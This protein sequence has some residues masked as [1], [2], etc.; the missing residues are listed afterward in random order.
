[1]CG[2]AGFVDRSE[3]DPNGALRR[4]LGLIAH[5]GPD[6][7]G[8]HFEPD[9]GLAM[10]TRRLSIID[11]EGGTQPIWSEDGN[12]GVT[13]NGE[14]FNYLELR[15][16]LEGKGHR[17]RTRSDTE[18]LVHLY[19]EAG[20]RMTERLRGM[21]AFCIF[22]RTRRRLL[23]ARDHFGQK[24]LYWVQQK[25]RFAFA[26]ELKALLSLPWVSH[27]LRPE[28]FLTYA[29]WLSLPGA[30]THFRCIHKALPGSRLQVPLNPPGEVRH[31]R[32][33]FHDISRN[34]SLG[35][36]D[37]AVEALDA[38]LRD[39]VG[40]HLR[41]DV[42]VGVLL[43]SGLDSRIVSTYAQELTGGTLQ[44]FTA[45]FGAEDSELAGAAATAREIGSK[46]H[47]LELTARDFAES[48]ERIAWHLDEP[49]GDPACF[50]VMRVCELA[51]G[52]VKVLLSGE[53]SDE[54]FAGYDGRYVGML[55]TM[56]RTRRFH[57]MAPFFP[58]GLFAS[59]SRWQRL[60]FRARAHPSEEIAEL[61]IEGLPGNVAQPRGLTMAQLHEL[62]HSIV[63]NAKKVPTRGGDT[64]I[65][66]LEFDISWQLA[67]SL[68]QKADKM[69]MAASIELRT[70]FLD[71][72]VAK[73]AAQIPSFLK[74]PPRGPGKFVLRQTLARKLNE[75]LKRPKKGFPVPLHS[76]FAGPLRDRVEAE[77][78]A[79]A[80]ATCEH[81][82][83]RLLRKAWK[84]FIHGHWDGGRAFFALWLY[85]TWRRVL[86]EPHTQ[87]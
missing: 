85:E 28:A 73:V 32:V 86:R 4:M 36:L 46:H 43:S 75:D 17:F 13:F 25:G 68:L 40:L 60:F 83:R 18:V 57:W 54:L 39:S 37:R 65:R 67:E 53:G 8:A 66:L 72:E 74:L 16:E 50:A 33:W 31:Q 24:P 11:L 42:P 81:L 56:R 1:M 10:G 62:Q 44:T 2:I 15:R 71:I 12:V 30:E 3:A 6:G 26:S 82:D 80:S 84:D 59:N 38:A 47:E 61:R 69:S 79:S 78:F 22:D 34:P 55:E 21:F 19:E 51:R 5:R 35:N 20:D 64:L 41:A 27:E 49:I 52:H 45:G 58:P 7:E 14:I 70:P 87:L 23:L 63:A 77:L 48:M 9:L 76:W 29:A